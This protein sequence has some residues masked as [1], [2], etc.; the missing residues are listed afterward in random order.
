VTK[1]LSSDLKRDYIKCDK[2]I[3]VMNTEADKAQVLSEYGDKCERKTDFSVYFKH[4]ANSYE[5]KIK[6]DINEAP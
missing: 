5:K 2:M 3:L 4:P 1:Q 6:I